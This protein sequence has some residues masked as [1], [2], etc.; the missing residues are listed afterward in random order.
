MVSVVTLGST[1][2]IDATKI[3]KMFQ[4]KGRVFWQYFSNTEL[5]IISAARCLDCVFILANYNKTLYQIESILD[6]IS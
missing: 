5:E 2:T 1:R 6:K 4:I 3:A